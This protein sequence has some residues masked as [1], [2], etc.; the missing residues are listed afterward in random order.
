MDR[1]AVSAAR[2][3]VTDLDGTL[4]GGDRRE[5]R[6]LRDALARHPHIK[7]VFATGRSLASV[8][9]LLRDDPLIPISHWIIADVGA[10]VIDGPRMLH[11]DA[12]EEQLRMGWPGAE[13]V[14]ARLSSFSQLVYQDGVA[15]EGRCSFHLDPTGLTGALRY[16]VK[17]LG[18]SWT[19]SSGRFFDV[20][21]VGASKGN[22]LELLRRGMG[23]ARQGVLAVGDSL[24]DLSMLST[25]THAVVVANAEVALAAAAPAREEVHHSVWEGAAAVLEGMERLGWLDCRSVTVGYHRP[26]V[27]WIDGGWR[28]P[29]SPN[30]ILPTLRSAL[31]DERLDA[32]WAAAHTGESAPTATA[33]TAAGV[34][35]SLLPLSPDRWAG[36]FHRA[37]KET[38]WP[39]LM[40]QPDLIRDLPEHWSD[41]ERVNVAFA[42]HIASLAAQG[43]TV[44]LHDYNLW[45]VPAVLKSRRPDLAV[46]LFHHTPFPQPE[47]FRR[48]PQAEQLI[49]SLAY[50]DWA[51]FHTA[52]SADNFRRLFT[53]AF[54]TTPQLG[55]H[56]LGI[57]RR[58]V[59]EMAKARLGHRRQ[60]AGGDT[61]LVLSV[62]RLD[63][64][65]APVR[66][67]Q[68]LDTLLAQ[69]PQLR[70]K[71]SYRLICPPPEPGIAAYDTT[72]EE[73]ESA[74]DRVNHRW[75]T[76]AWQP[77]DYIPHNLDFPAV[78]DH[79]LAAD[80]F[81]VTSL[82]DGMNLTAQ[83]YVTTH[84][85][86]HRPG[87]LVLSRYAG[88]ARHTGSAA[89]LT[90]PHSER[91]L[92]ATLRTALAMPVADRT[93]HINRLHD[94]LDLPAP[95]QWARAC[96]TAIHRS[97]TPEQ[98]AHPLTPA[99]HAMV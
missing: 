6:R 41:Y 25:G 13:Q 89:L 64:A 7:V 3:L 79:Y 38:L 44:W 57:D 85:A 60:G 69:T 77:V 29:C 46:G 54:R 51:G 91:D 99:A 20:L 39:A 43:G 87:T 14:R 62:E 81:W 65:K 73:L 66:K 53:S 76:A 75:A 86:T 72:R 52:D 96:I 80:V 88:V 95:D 67:I 90:D 94:L 17:D 27:R 92:V 45:L 11:V 33:A 56:P 26:P 19:Y 24:N 8:R 12:L 32:V 5:R 22:A 34:S 35:L 40:S 23:W 1:R 93:A 18:C 42:R 71:V 97:R 31:A 70:E 82:A 98:P 36:Y 49:S 68:A 59:A 2:V 4:L 61:Q 63:Y 37:C 47:V 16:A 28:S 84:H 55:V 78:V 58:A 30:G 15:Q 10:S 83:E 50:L 74:V 9:E 21:P 48:I